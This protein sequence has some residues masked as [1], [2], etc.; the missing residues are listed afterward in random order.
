M[1]PRLGSGWSQTVCIQEQRGHVILGAAP[2]SQASHLFSS[3]GPPPAAVSHD[4]ERTSEI[5]CVKT[6][7]PLSRGEAFEE[8]MS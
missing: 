5:K 3:L 4:T 2:H 6:L 1:Q 7:G 8:V